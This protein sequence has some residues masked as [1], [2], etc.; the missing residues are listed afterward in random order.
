M[1]KLKSNNIKLLALVSK[2]LLNGQIAKE[3]SRAFFKGR[4]VAFGERNL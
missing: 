3:G 2:E 4:E 1:A